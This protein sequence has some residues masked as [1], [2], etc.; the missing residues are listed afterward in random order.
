MAYYWLENLD[1]GRVR[2]IAFT[3]TCRIACKKSRLFDHVVITEEIVPS[4]ISKII[5]S[6]ICPAE[7]LDKASRFKEGP[8]FPVSQSYS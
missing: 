5:L 1:R 2:K 7:T 8:S 3:A 6:F 4:C